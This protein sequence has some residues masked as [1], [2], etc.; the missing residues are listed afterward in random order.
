VGGPG[1]G[2]M[3][4][5]F[6]RSAAVFVAAGMPRAPLDEIEHRLTVCSTCPQFD[7]S[8]YGGMGKCN[9]CGCNMEVKSVMATE[10]CPEGKWLAYVKQSED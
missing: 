7:P 5:S 1:I 9:V 4:L 6:F 8:G 10:A 2:Q 3:A